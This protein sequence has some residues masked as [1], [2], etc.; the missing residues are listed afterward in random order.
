M[1]VSTWIYRQEDFAMKWQSV[2]GGAMALA[3][4]A[5]TGAVGNNALHLPPNDFLMGNHIDSHMENKLAADGSL[6]G[7]LYVY[8]TGEID[9]ASGLPVARH[10][11]GAGEHNEECGF[12][13]IQCVVGWRVRAVP[14]E[15]VFVSHSGVNGDDHPI[16][17]INTRNGIPQP[18]SYTHFHW[19]TSKSSDERW[20][21]V[22]DA[23]DVRMAGML[24]GDV[25]TGDLV[26][27]DNDE[28]PAFTWQDSKVHVGGGAE[29]LACPGWLLELTA[30]REF[31]F[32]HGGE[33]IAVSRGI[34]SSTHL[35][36]ATNYA[37]V[38][39]IEGGHAGGG[40]HDGEH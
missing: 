15:A 32:Q 1:R 10:P 16:W 2:T 17:L 8:Y 24:E 3:L 6:K 27:L 33:K 35:N 11:R 34:D 29:N 36:I 23:C 28:N 9:E 18:G 12:D 40:G 37:I 25:L 26:L 5:L 7:R 19:I 13:P 38:P 39:E 31:A 14:A 22:P 4:P 30:I 21:Q 20:D